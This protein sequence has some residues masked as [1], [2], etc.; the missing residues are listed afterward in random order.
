MWMR[1]ELKLKAKKVLAKNYC[2]LLGVWLLFIF[3]FFIYL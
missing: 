2:K 1:E 3:I